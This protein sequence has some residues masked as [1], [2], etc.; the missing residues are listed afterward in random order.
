MDVPAAI[1]DSG[2]GAE[3]AELYQDAG[4]ELG[5]LAGLLI[6]ILWGGAA[7][8]KAIFSNWPLI[9]AGGLSIGAYSLVLVTPRYVG[10]SAVLLFV[11]ILA[12]IRLPRKD[13]TAPLHNM[14]L[15]R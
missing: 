12:G 1:T 5:L 10:G 15:R 14:W 11:A 3:C 8:R 2:S 4:G 13:Q 6:F 7:T 9:A